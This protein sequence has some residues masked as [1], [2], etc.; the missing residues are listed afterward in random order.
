MFKKYHYMQ[1]TFSATRGSIGLMGKT[2]L[3]AKVAATT[4]AAA[5]WK[6]SACLL[7]EALEPEETHDR[8]STGGDEL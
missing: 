3:S 1:L 8:V 2:P 7:E 4:S 5:Q 6:R